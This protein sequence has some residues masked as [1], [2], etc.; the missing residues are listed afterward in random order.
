[1]TTSW[2]DFKRARFTEG[3]IR[4]QDAAVSAEL[5]GMRELHE[6]LGLTEADLEHLAN[7]THDE[8]ARFV[9]PPREA[10]RIAYARELVAA[11]GGGLEV[12][13]VLRGRRVR[14]A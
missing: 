9:L 1:M 5:E 10:E 4:E 6:A 8:A 13:A 2:R 3:Q 11:L 7:V 14:V 12:F